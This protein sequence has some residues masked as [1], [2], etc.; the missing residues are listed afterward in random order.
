LQSRDPARERRRQVVRP[1]P[2]TLRR[3]GS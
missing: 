3:R 2:R 1:E